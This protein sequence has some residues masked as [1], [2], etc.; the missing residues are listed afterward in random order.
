MTSQQ[1]QN[2]L[3]QEL[4]KHRAEV[5][6]LRNLLNGLDK[7]KESWFK[8]K[9]EFSKKI[10][11]AI[12]LIKSSKAK[13]DLLT[14]EVKQLKP[15]RDGINRG[16]SQK[17][18]ELGNL[19]KEK[20]KLEKSLNIRESP[21]NIKQSIEKL[22]FKIE[23]EPMPFDKEQALM[24][25]IKELKKLYENADIMAEAGKKTDQISDVIKGMRKEANENHRLI[26]EKAKESQIL[27][28][29]ILKISAEIDNMKDEEQDAFKK[30]SEFKK[31]FKEANAELK[32]KL[33]IMNDIKEELD[34]INFQ[35]NEIIKMQQELFLKSKEE[36]IQQKIKRREKLTT[37][38]LL[39]FQKF[40]NK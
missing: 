38:D 34:K 36:E 17:L 3:V 37:E 35:K 25:R 31:R 21:S 1:S 32:E 8:K 28:E 23:T 22:E 10:K 20:I 2:Q 14:N 7:E 4:N 6:T 13:R 9:E 24:R 40:S 39:V 16:I 29:G 15:K 30:F 26:Q 27:H 19:R 18:K 5:S 11:E 12:Q 33:K